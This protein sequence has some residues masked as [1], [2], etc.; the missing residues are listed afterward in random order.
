MF[1]IFSVNNSS[2]YVNVDKRKNTQLYQNIIEYYHSRLF[3]KISGLRESNTHYGIN[4]NLFNF[5]LNKK[6]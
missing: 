5:I 1:L 6:N 3:L 4:H 2:F